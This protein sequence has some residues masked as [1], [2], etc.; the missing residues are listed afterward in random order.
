MVLFHNSHEKDEMIAHFEGNVDARWLVGAGDDRDMK[1]LADFAFVDGAGFRWE[2]KKD[3]TV[4]GA[5]IP[6]V[7]WS[8][9]VGTPYIG[10]Y[11]RAS[12]VHDVACTRHIK[13]SKD[14]ARMFYE[15]M[16]A[17]G[18]PQPRALLFYTAVRLFGPQW[19]AAVGVSNAE[20]KA[21]FSLKVKN[22]SVDFNK[23]ERA[24]DEAIVF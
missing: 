6:T 11:R 2:A 1:L 23:F 15:A 10:D 22:T 7:V 17:D 24:L 8:E 21:K 3:D 19:E 9:I 14:A 4:N 16:L 20:F 13:T 5:S 12:V 18:T